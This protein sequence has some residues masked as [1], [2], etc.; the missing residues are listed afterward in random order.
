[1]ARIVARRLIVAASPQVLPPQPL[2]FK[3]LRLRTPIGNGGDVWLAS[4]GDIRSPS[5]RYSLP[6]GVSE[7]LKIAN[8]SLI[9]VWG[10][11]PGD[12]VDVIAEIE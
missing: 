10:S 4:A 12:T 2:V 11:N 5:M 9:W 1:M 6:P 3:E 8:L 7:P